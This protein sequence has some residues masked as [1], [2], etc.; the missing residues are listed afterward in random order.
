MI[1]V[2]N[3]VI[4]PFFID[5][6]RTAA[7]ERLRTVDHYWLVPP[8]WRYEFTNVLFTLIRAGRLRLPDALHALNEARVQLSSREIAVDQL[9]VIKIAQRYL[10]SAYDAQY[11]A[12][13]EQY[14]ITC[15]T[16]DA[17]LAARAGETAV[18]LDRFLQLK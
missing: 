7:A 13:A 6:Q 2:D 5:H 11:V 16:D 8:L 12:V 9:V 4:V 10:L 17:I 18:T 15:V 3:S 14:G 1:V